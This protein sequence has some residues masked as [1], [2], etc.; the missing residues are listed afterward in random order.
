MRHPHVKVIG[1]SLPGVAGTMKKLCCGIV[2]RPEGVL[3]E[4][5]VFNLSKSKSHQLLSFRCR[6]V[7]VIVGRLEEAYLS[8]QS[9]SSFGTVTPAPCISRSEMTPQGCD[10]WRIVYSWY[11]SNGSCSQRD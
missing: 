2:I 1:S 5:Q 9:P 8:R 6:L 7:V 10:R 11:I 3:Q 4:I